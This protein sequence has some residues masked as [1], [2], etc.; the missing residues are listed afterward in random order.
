MGREYAFSKEPCPLLGQCSK[1]TDAAL[2]TV[3]R[4]LYDVKVEV[5]R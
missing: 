1:P 5:V 4:M 2:R 3:G